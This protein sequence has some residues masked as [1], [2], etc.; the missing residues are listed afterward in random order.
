MRRPILIALG[1]ASMLGLV[2]LA[3]FG[4]ALARPMQP[5]TLAEQISQ[6]EPESCH[7][8]T[9][10]ED[11]MW[12]SLA[13]ALGMTES[14]L[15][16]KIEAGKNLREIAKARGLDDQQLTAVV[17]SAMEDELER[18]V[19]DG[20]LAQADADK[21]IEHMTQMGSDH[22]VDMMGGEGDGCHG[23]NSATNMQLF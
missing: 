16:A 19:Q 2:G 13:K 8:D 21:M 6:Q 3:L 20:H 9:G 11:P 22:P 4:M 5:T 12:G 1:T 14:A 23:G 18:H 15:V 17:R 10:G 7:V